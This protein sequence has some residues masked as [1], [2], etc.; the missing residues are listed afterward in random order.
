M[1]SIV[2]ISVNATTR[3]Q[4]NNTHPQDTP[5]VN[6]LLTYL[7]PIQQWVMHHSNRTLNPSSPFS[8]P[9]TPPTNVKIHVQRHTCRIKFTEN[10]AVHLLLRITDHESIMVY[11]QM[12]AALTV[13]V[14]QLMTA[15]SAADCAATRL[16]SEAAAARLS[17]EC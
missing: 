8:N 13:S 17:V 16:M 3:K 7:L 2:K 14:N 4:T 5:K 10:Q 1:A 9:S 11:F 12:L 15:V 6:D